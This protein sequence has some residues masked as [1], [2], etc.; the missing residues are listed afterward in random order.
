MTVIKRAIMVGLGA[1][2]GMRIATLMSH[3]MRE[4]MGK[5]MREHCGQMAAQ[6]KRMAEQFEGRGEAVGRT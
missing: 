2:I 1:I 3:R 6:C 5:K 4:Q